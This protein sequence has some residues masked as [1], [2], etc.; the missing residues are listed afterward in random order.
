MVLK[1][2]EASSAL[3]LRIKN[4]V[5]KQST[6]KART[7]HLRTRQRKPAQSGSCLKR[8]RSLQA[9]ARN[10]NC[11]N[12]SLSKPASRRSLLKQPVL[13]GRRRLRKQQL[14]QKKL[15]VAH[16]PRKRKMW[17][18]QPSRL[19]QGSR[20]LSRRPRRRM[21]RLLRQQQN[22]RPNHRQRVRLSLNNHLQRRSERFSLLQRVPDLELQN[23]LR[24]PRPLAKAALWRRVQSRR[25]LQSLLPKQRNRQLKVLWKPRVWAAALRARPEMLSALWK[26]ESDQL[27]DMAVQKGKTAFGWTIFRTSILQVLWFILIRLG[28]AASCLSDVRWPSFLFSLVMVRTLLFQVDYSSIW[29]SRLLNELGISSEP[30]I[31]EIQLIPHSSRSL[32]FTSTLIPTLLPLFIPILCAHSVDTRGLSSLDSVFITF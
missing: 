8:Q 26:V 27:N 16:P 21:R 20:P 2:V 12:Q 31:E 28:V 25:A 22:Q 5:S 3:D 11:L 4:N 13:V 17:S 6:R 29:S 30:N 14:L 24:P 10:A 23:P 19:R 32:H 1:I 7:P 15:P 9:L 18:S